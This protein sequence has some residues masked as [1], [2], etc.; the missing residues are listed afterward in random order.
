M[1]LSLTVKVE[2]D[3]IPILKS[4]MLENIIRLT[5]FLLGLFIKTLINTIWYPEKKINNKNTHR[6]CTCQH[7]V[8]IREHSYGVWGPSLRATSHMS[9]EP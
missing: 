7:N 1:L 9:Q 3:N 8:F 4:L 2:N 6:Y 5:E